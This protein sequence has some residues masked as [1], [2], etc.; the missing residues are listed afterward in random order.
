MRYHRATARASRR[1]RADSGA[2]RP[3]TAEAR[4]AVLGADRTET[5]MTT[6]PFPR[7]PQDEAR[8]LAHK[9]VKARR[10]LGAH[11]VT[12]IVVNAFLVVVW[13][14]TDQGGYFW[15]AWVLAGW[16]IGLALNAWDVLM[17]RPIS[18]SD[19]EREMRRGRSAR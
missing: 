10:D 15:P 7:T 2:R 13:W 19:I 5:V 12:Y 4:S 11:A 17:R 16:G 3:A 9:R 18:E 14:F 8:R 6:P 1:P